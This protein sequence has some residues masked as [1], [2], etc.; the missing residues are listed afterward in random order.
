MSDYILHS[1]QR[2]ILVLLNASRGIVTAKEL[3]GKLGVSERTLRSDIAS[4]NN[5]VPEKEIRIISVRGKGYTLSIKDRSGFLELFSDKQNY[6]S[7][8]DRVRTMI[9]ILLSKDDWYSIS[10]C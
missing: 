3:A 10:S 6:I 9:L 4:I 7:R 2:K 5:I 1:R 8:E